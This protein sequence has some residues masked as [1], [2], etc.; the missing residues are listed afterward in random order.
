MAHHEGTRLGI[1]SENLTRGQRVYYNATADTI[2]AAT[3]SL[4]ANGT[5]RTDTLSGKSGTVQLLSGSGTHV[6]IASAAVVAGDIV[7]GAAAGKVST[8]HTPTEAWKALQAASGDGAQFEAEFLDYRGPLNTSPAATAL[9]AAATLTAAQ[10]RAGEFTLAHAT[11][12]TVALTTPTGT[13]MDTAF[14]EVPIGGL[15]PNIHH[16]FR[17]I[18][19][20]A[21]LADTG[22]LTAGA[23]GVTLLGSVIMPSAHASGGGGGIGCNAS[24]FIAKRTAANTWVFSRN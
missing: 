18:N 15:V 1:A 8:T 4:P 24:K 20:S 11:G 22:T 13:E 21:A 16:G 3:A 17:V 2:A 19:T 23:S 12:G 14:P 7:F 9:T 5:M 10:I 6:L